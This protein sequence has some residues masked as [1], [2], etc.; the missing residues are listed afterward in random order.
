[1]TMLRFLAFGRV[2]SLAVLAVLLGSAASAQTQDWR[3]GSS[4][5]LTASLT[6]P[7]SEFRAVVFDVPTLAQRLAAA[8]DGDT[9]TLPLP[10]GDEVEVETTEAS[11]M[12]PALQ[13][14]YPQIRTYTF[15]GEGVR[16]RLAVTPLGV[17]ALIFTDTGSVTILPSTSDDATHAVYHT[18]DA[19]PPANLVEDV[20]ALGVPHGRKG[21]DDDGP[22]VIGDS[23]VTY[24]M[25]AAATG[26][27]TQEV[28]GTVANGLAAVVAAVN[29][30]AAVFE[31][32]LS[33]SFVLVDKNDQLIFT[34][35]GSDPYNPRSTNSETTFSA[36]RTTLN[37]RIG[38]DNYDVGHV[39]GPFDVGGVAQLNSFCRSDKGASKANG[40]SRYVR[41]EPGTLE[42]FYHEVGHQAGAPHTWVTNRLTP[43]EP[44]NDAGVEPST[45]FTIMSYGSFARDNRPGG[46]VTGVYFHAESIRIMNDYLRFDEN[47]TCGTVTE[48]GNDVPTVTLAE[49]SYTIPANTPF[50]LTGSASDASGTTLL[51]TWEQMDQYGTADGTSRPLFRSLDPR[52]SPTRYFP[53]PL[54]EYFDETLPTASD[55]YRFRLTARDNVAGHGGVGAADVTV[56]TDDSV[57]PLVVTFAQEGGEQ[58]PFGDTERVTWQVTRTRRLSA[59]VDILFSADGGRTFPFTLAEGVPNDGS[60]TVEF[61]VQTRE[62]RVMVKA[63]TNVFY[64]LSGTFEVQRYPVASVTPDRVRETVAQDEGAEGTM[65]ISN[66]VSEDGQDL[67]WTARV[68]N[69]EGPTGEPPANGCSLGQTIAQPNTS[70]D[71][72]SISA[73]N[74]A[75]VHGQSF[76]ALCTGV[77][78]RVEL[79]HAGSDLVGQ[80]WSG[81]L[82]VYASPSD[83]SSFDLDNPLSESDVAGV[84]PADGEWMVLPLEAPVAVEAG[85]T[86]AF[87]LEVTSGQTRYFEGNNRSYAGGV[88]YAVDRGT[89]GVPQSSRDLAFRLTFGEPTTFLRLESYAGT[90]APGESE[91]VGVFFDATGYSRGRYSATIAVTT[92]ELGRDTVKTVVV[93]MFVT[94]AVAQEDG[95]AA[96]LPGT[97]QDAVGAESIAGSL[98]PPPARTGTRSP[99]GAASQA[100]ANARAGGETADCFAIDVTD[101][102]MFSATTV[103]NGTVADTDLVLFTPDGEAIAAQ[104][105]ADGTFQSRLPAEALA[106]R[107]PGRY[108]LC[109][110]ATLTNPINGRG[111]LL[112]PVLN[113]EFG[114]LRFP[115]APSGDYV[116]ASF[117]QIDPQYGGPYMVDLTGV[118]VLVSAEGAVPVAFDLG[119]VSP[120]PTRGGATVTLSLPEAGEIGVS[121]YDAMG[122]LVGEYRQPA[123]S[124]EH[125]LAVPVAGVAPGVYLVRVHTPSGVGVQR[126]T[127]VR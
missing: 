122:R 79:I 60:Q 52:P 113:N 111:E 4:A 89:R 71:R 28:G 95:D 67:E 105:D 66:T 10:D 76:T 102:A 91:D 22:P 90:V 54:V 43:T 108:V 72:F 116:I 65:T 112:I 20:V 103:G 127:V 57:G 87:F 107:G 59:N 46:P 81:T 32:D 31:R 55:T 106:G 23:L 24:R 48:T 84:N 30:L 96:D 25:A 100:S 119:P 78:T 75:Q 34:N 44:I 8:G 2:L 18:H 109:V 37:A 16:G 9:I 88:V 74:E 77:L 6:A 92:N 110:T 64:N 82:R 38:A 80:E 93:R 42:I 123:P 39:L 12:E 40:F 56:T 41:S 63:S 17:D 115:S 68:T 104:D 58:F 53:D 45:G 49:E 94:E 13:A 36:N 98:G 120:N 99:K 70:R 19:P 61:P 124:G 47:Y 73:G 5:A 26:E 69:A 11:I 86:Y 62:G 97:A 3:D 125:R 114:A 126:M 27:L 121:V 7:P 118:G 117:P 14:R 1:M 35:A 50:V 101:P 21:D 51:Y 29:N 33:V 83:Q 15:T 85:R